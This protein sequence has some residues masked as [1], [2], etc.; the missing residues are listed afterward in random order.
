LVLSGGI[1]LV[2]LVR[3]DAWNVSRFLFVTNK[4]R[5][6]AGASE[7]ITYLDRRWVHESLASMFAGSSGLEGWRIEDGPA[8]LLEAGAGTALVLV[9]DGEKAR[10]LV[11]TVT[12]TALAAAPG[13]DVFGVVSGSFEWDAAGGLAAP[14]REVWR[15]R[16]AARASRPGPD[17]RFLR[18]PV[19][20]EC[21]STGLPAA[22]LAVDPDDNLVER[23]AESQAKWEAYGKE[24]GADGLA[25][26]AELAGVT[27]PDLRRMV[28]HLNDSAD[29]VG[30]VY[31]D[32]NGPGAVFDDFE[33]FA[34]D[35]SNR[36][37][38]DGLRGFS[39]RLRACAAS[40]LRAA[41]D[42]TR[43]L[44]PAVD[45]LA[46]VL[47][48]IV[49]GDDL[50][51]FARLDCA[52]DRSRRSRAGG[53][54]PRRIRRDA[55]GEYRDSVISTRGPRCSRTFAARNV[56]PRPG[57]SGKWRG[58]WS[59]WLRQRREALRRPRLG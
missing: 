38:A 8:E 35:P 59:S 16:D 10:R 24:G 56:R 5:E 1:V 43:G 28:R 15:G 44:L 31:A 3:F 37:Y 25:R 46:P 22:G 54:S 9:R 20:D 58:A 40:A 49:G 36:G 29:W 51:V 23:S 2:H 45:G 57:R 42:Q 55:D 41:V 34:P 53:R 26:L 27:A 21:A 19:M 18:L 7:L 30:V 14:V 6:I 13:L 48:L 52:R 50:V 12:A 4:R 39:A 11:S 32:A 17:L 47:P 33:R